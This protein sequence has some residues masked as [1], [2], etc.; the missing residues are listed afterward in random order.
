MNE[1][2]K[3][4]KFIIVFAL[5]FT[6]FIIPFLAM[7]NFSPAVD[8]IT[9][10]ASG[11]A[12]LKTGEIKLNPQ[13]PPLIKILAAFPLLFLDIKFNPEN[14]YFA[15]AELK[16]WKF[17]QDFFFENNPDRIIFWGRIP[18]ILL[19][20]VLGWVIF[21]WGKE[22]FG[23]GAGV[24]GLFLYAF[25]P[26][27]IAHSQ[28]VTTDI[29][30][31]AFSFISLYCLWSFYKS[32][33]KNRWR[34]VFSGVFLGLAL[35]TKFS[36]IFLIPIFLILSAVGIREKFKNSTSLAKTNSFLK[37]I[38][39]LLAITFFLIWLIYLLPSGST[40]YWEG[41][42]SVYADSNAD[43]QYYLNGNFKSEGWW[44]YF[45]WA[46][47]IKTPIPFL[48]ILFLSVWGSKKSGLVSTDRLFIFLPVAVFLFVA[49]WKAHNIGVRYILPIYPFLILFVG[50]WLSDKFGILNLESIFSNFASNFKFKNLNIKIV[51]I[52]ILL[53]WYVFSAARIYPDYLAYF[54]ELI[55][56]S[57]K[58]YK[59]L[60]DSN[61]EWGQDL[62]RLFKYQ[63]E[64][65]DLRVAYVWDAYVDA[66]RLYGI[67]NM[68]SLNS[69]KLWLT[70][71][72][73]YAISAHA[74]IRTR[75]AGQINKN[76]RINWM[77]SYKPIDRIGQSF[78][79]YEFP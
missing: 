19:S 1:K 49:S 37:I 59:Y 50:G 64:S 26:N 38:L 54:N 73:K 8:E 14:Q 44:Y 15:G 25:M 11:Y 46:F 53:G 52:L 6:V 32:D 13:H 27:I 4:T 77:D 72:G 10:L 12:Y 76:E 9:H 43:Y 5:L 29:G 35:G 63:V 18:V 28:L 65:P 42:N 55:G 2:L 75:L 62:K 67:R 48:I 69:E 58:G 23:F 68:E 79:I 31:A 57:G 40:F 24:A 22:L 41:L 56:G 47:V 34:L 60:D 17:G 61:I 71:K 3:T 45:L 70:P 21:K 51:A 16:E 30:L 78:F 7:R 36:A 74:I 66:N 39:P 20:V 33:F